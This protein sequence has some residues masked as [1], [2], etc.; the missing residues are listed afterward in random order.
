MTELVNIL[1]AKQRDVFGKYNKFT[2]THSKDNKKKSFRS[3]LISTVTD[4]FSS[5]CPCFKA[6]PVNGILPFS[7]EMD[8]FSGDK[9]GCN[10]PWE[11]SRVYSR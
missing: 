7:I 5:F 1:Y 4:L 8:G 3:L 9:Q 6:G 11:D 10:S 2:A